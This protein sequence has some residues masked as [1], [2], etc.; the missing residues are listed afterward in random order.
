MAEV[1]NRTFFLADAQNGLP[2]FSLLRL[3]GVHYRNKRIRVS[4]LPGFDFLPVLE[5]EK[6]LQIALDLSFQRN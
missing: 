6:A 3:T 1:I 4:A 5:R 2:V